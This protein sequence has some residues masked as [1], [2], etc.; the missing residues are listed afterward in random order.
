MEQS[1]QSAKKKILIVEDELFIRELYVKVLREDGYEISEAG[2][3]ET[4]YEAIHTGGFDLVLLDIMLPK[5]D[6]LSILEKLQKNPPLQPNNA[7]VLLTNL[8][9]ELTIAK[10]VELGIR[11]YII[12]SQSTPRQLKQE[13]AAYLSV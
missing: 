10:G 4:G 11:G 12:K 7:I 6:G 13:V 8:Y 2:D 9:Q 3:G 1:S 5:M